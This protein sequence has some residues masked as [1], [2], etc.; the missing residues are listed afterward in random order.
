M[1]NFGPFSRGQPYKLD[2][3]HC[4]YLFQ[5]EV[6]QEPHNEVG[7]LSPAKYVVG[8]EPGTF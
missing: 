4:F 8:F 1:A 2:V 7:S 6:Y 3:N 5:P